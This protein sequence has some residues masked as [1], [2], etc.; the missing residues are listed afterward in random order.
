MH[1]R[2]R[3]AGNASPRT[4]TQVIGI[5]SK[6]KME[7]ECIQTEPQSNT[8]AQTEHLEHVQSCRV[9]FHIHTNG[10]NNH[11]ELTGRERNSSEALR[12]LT[13]ILTVQH[14]LF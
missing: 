14:R 9:N 10:E 11:S 4:H 5:Y 13:I 8:Y 2:E 6:H 7:A 12:C 1:T 3:K